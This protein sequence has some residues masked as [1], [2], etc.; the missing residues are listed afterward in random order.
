MAIN[1]IN[2]MIAEQ[3]QQQQPM[4]APEFTPEQIAYLQM[5]AQQDDIQPQEVEAIAEGQDTQQLQAPESAPQYSPEE[6]Q[7][8]QQY[9]QAMQQQAAQPTEVDIQTEQEVQPE[10]IEEVAEETAD[11]K[12]NV[13]EILNAETSMDVNI[14]EEQNKGV[15]TELINQR[16]RDE[17]SK[18]IELQSKN[19]ELEAMVRYQQNLIDKQSDKQFGY[20]DR[21]KEL[22]SELRR[23]QG[24]SVP[25][26]LSKIA[27]CF[28]LYNE[29]K[30]PLHKW[31]L[32]NEMLGFLQNMSGVSGED[33]L[34][35]MFS[36]EYKDIPM[37]DTYVAP[38][39]NLPG[40]DEKPQ[41]MS[42]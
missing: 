22:E 37:P 32:V 1:K 3:S 8:Y 40:K 26:G 34:Q 24:N 23:L 41:F 28:S 39:V 16:L 10:Q 29:H 19:A 5:L 6:L 4:Q 12:K 11:Y 13:E 42:F 17:I 20:I 30:T 15:D 7:A 35:K 14:T 33:Y 31:A 18:R 25:E 36:A 27:E 9:L 38:T 2:Q 21:Q